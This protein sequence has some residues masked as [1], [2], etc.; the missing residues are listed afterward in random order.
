MKTPGR[1]TADQDLPSSMPKRQP[2]SSPGGSALAPGPI[3]ARHELL[4]ADAHLVDQ[5]KR[6]RVGG[7]IDEFVHGENGLAS[8]SGR[9]RIAHDRPSASC[10]STGTPA[11][12]FPP[13]YVND[14]SRRWRPPDLLIADERLARHC[15]GGNSR[16]SWSRSLA[17]HVVV[18]ARSSK[19][20]RSASA[21]TTAGD[22]RCRPFRGA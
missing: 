21:P 1:R 7:G 13:G 14:G 16:W 15:G 10:S 18:E 4:A 2:P 22:S 9:A 6:R 5:A 3:A 11:G 20:R 12:C 19:C 8:A 17:A